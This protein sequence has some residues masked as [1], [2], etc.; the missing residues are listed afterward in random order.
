M[1]PLHLIIAA[2]AISTATLC[3]SGQRL[4]TALHNDASARRALTDHAGI[5]R[6]VALLRAQS[7]SAA[8][9]KRP[10]P[11]IVGQVTRALT[12]ADASSSLE[13]VS[14]EPDQPAPAKPGAAPGYRRQVARITLDS[15]TL[16]ALARFLNAWRTS[17]PEWTITSIQISADAPPRPPQRPLRVLL[18]IESIYLPSTARTE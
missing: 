7:P 10:Q 16:P 12:E 4:L 2:A 17:Q 1:K 15:I 13:S 14:P 18:S 3:W 9:A 11:G 6:E 5:V 8:L